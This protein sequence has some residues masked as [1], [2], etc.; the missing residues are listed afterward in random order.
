MNDI[1]TF[2]YWKPFLEEGAEKNDSSIK[3]IYG[4]PTGGS[5]LLTE[6]ISQTE[7][8]LIYGATG[9]G[10]SNFLHTFIK[11]NMLTTSSRDMSLVLVDAKRVELSCYKDSEYL[12][13]PI[14]KNEED[15]LK[16]INNIL[17]EAHKREE[18]LKG[19]D[20]SLIGN[21]PRIIMIIDEYADLINEEINEAMSTL[22]KVGHRV[23]IHVILATQRVNKLISKI[24]LVDKFKTVICLANCD[25][26]LTRKLF[27]VI[28]KLDGFGDSLI[29]YQG[30]IIRCQ[31]LYMT[32]ND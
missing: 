9:S 15:F 27:G 3:V 29:R 13:C 24:N 2:K 1:V 19:N 23:G 5:L 21:L 30:K 4:V 10:K 6:N 22:L 14:V 28:Y 26:K 32:F 8:V 31:E 18:L 11:G 12:Y 25:D 7:N 17:I 20:F 16:T